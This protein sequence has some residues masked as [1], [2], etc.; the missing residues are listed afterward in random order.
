MKNIRSNNNNYTWADLAI[1]QLIIMEKV[2]P[3]EEMIKYYDINKDGKIT[4]LD[5]VLLKEKLMQTNEK[6]GE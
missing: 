3:C 6:Q 5:Y 1:I 2:V 4:S